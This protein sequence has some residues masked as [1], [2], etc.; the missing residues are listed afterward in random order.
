VKISVI[1]PHYDDLDNLSVCLDML[2]RQTISREAFEIIVADNMSKCGLEAVEAVAAGRAR[3]ILASERG[4]GP[5]RNTAAAAARA[6]ALAFIDSDCRPTPE[7]L[8]E[9]LAALAAHPIAGG[10]VIIEPKDANRISDIEAFDMVF[11]FDARTYLEKHG[12][13]GSGNLFVRRSVFEQVGG[14]RSGVAEDVEWSHRAVSRGF[15][16][17]HAP[18]AVVGHPARRDWSELVRK[19]DKQTREGYLLMREKRLGLARWLVRSWLLPLSPFP[20]IVKVLRSKRLLSSHD[21][22]RAIGVL[23]RIRFYRFCE[24]HRVMVNRSINA[25]GKDAGLI[26]SK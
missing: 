25:V 9:G 13:I 21:R 15:P 1:I 22:R 11:G 12:F 7:W 16:L 19:W 26:S 18:G 24:A 20:H 23:F 14:F 8:R 10:P 6:D 17:H 5:A 3:V 4:A 2:D